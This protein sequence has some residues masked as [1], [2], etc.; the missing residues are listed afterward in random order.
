DLYNAVIGEMFNEAG[1]P[2]VL[3]KMNARTRAAYDALR[4]AL[5]STFETFNKGRAA[6]GLPPIN[7]REFYLASRWKGNFKAEIRGPDGKLLYF[8]RSPTKMGLNSQIKAAQKAVPGTTVKRIPSNYQ[9]GSHLDFVE[10]GYFSM[11][12]LLD[13]NDPRVAA[14]KSVYEEHVAG[15][16]EKA[17]GMPFHAEAKGNVRGFIGDRPNRTP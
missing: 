8:L 3:E 13:K 7:K 4:D 11:L 15:Q 1:N 2:M 14:L 12:E 16:G 9:R 5:D 6:A 10:A 17:L